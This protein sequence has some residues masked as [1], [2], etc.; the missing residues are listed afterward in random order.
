MHFINKNDWQTRGDINGV[1]R[2]RIPPAG[3]ETPISDGDQRAVVLSRDGEFPNQ[4]CW[5]F[6]QR[7]WP[8]TLRC[9]RTNANGLIKPATAPAR[10]VVFRNKE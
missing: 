5:H 4:L 7:A 9:Q 6:E 3:V 1:L 2:L 10:R 8:N